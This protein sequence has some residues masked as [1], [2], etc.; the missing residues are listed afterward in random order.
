MKRNIFKAFPAFAMM[1]LLASCG[2]FF[3]QESDHVI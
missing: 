3:D 2:D 1:F